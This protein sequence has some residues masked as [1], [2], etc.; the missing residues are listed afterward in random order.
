MEIKRAKYEGTIRVPGSKSQTIRAF[1]IAFASRGKSTIHSP[2]LSADTKSC[3]SSIKAL[4]AKVE[5]GDDTVAIDSTELN[6]DEGK[7]IIVDAGNSGTTLALLAPIVATMPVKCTFTGDE[8]LKKRPF[9]PLL[10]SLEDLGATVESKDGFPPFTIEGP[11][12]G[13]ETTIECKTS[14]YLSGLLLATPLAK[15]NS[16]INCSL[17]FEKPY[18]NMT[19]EWLNR[20]KIKYS[21]TDDLM[22][23]F[24]EGGQ[25]YIL[26]EE[27]IEGDYS[28]ATF[29][30]VLA[31]I[32][33]TTIKL[34]NLKENTT[35]GDK[36]V[37][38]IIQKMGASVSRLNDNEVIVKGPE[39][40]S[41]GEFDIN[42]IPDALP[43]LAVLAAFAK[44]K[45]ILKN[46]EQARIKETDRISVMKDELEKL[47]VD[48]EE[49]R[50]GLIINGKGHI[51]GGKV[52]GHKDHRII[53][54]LA[55]AGTKADTEVIIDDTKEA[56]VT[57]P[58]FFTLLKSLEV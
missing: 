32:Q 36:R 23:S 19:L 40:L 47:N 44:G 6:L 30:M 29:F 16:N 11:I 33:G 43:S 17:L 14:Q 2:L 51:S 34:S 35:Q 12:K 53:M 58:T 49:M 22:H 55:I 5:I 15:G 8:Q 18:V 56:D 4:G 41:G 24:V 1:L 13:G 27:T 31:A 45:T 37:L 50:D 48:I 42:D 46:V 10:S 25:H 57:F 7:E 38:E 26:K 9:G 20:E 52:S 21:I 39:V 54:A 3:L 28:S